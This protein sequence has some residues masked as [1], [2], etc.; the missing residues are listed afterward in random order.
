MRPNQPWQ[1]DRVPA[2]N[3]RSGSQDDVRNTTAL[4]NA[5]S[6]SF[7]FGV[8]IDGVRKGVGLLDVGLVFHLE[9]HAWRADEHHPLHAMG[10]TGVHHMLGGDDVGTFKRTRGSHL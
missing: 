7:G 3:Q 10:Q 5:F 1:N 2:P 6:L 9:I 8:H 4:N